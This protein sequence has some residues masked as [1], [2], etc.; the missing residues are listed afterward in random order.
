MKKSKGTGK[1]QDAH[2]KLV[3]RVVALLEQAIAPG[4]RV[5]HNVEL[6]DHK[7]KIMTQC[8][9]VIRQG[10][11]PRETITIVEVQERNRK[12]EL[13]DFRGWC[14]KR[15]DVGAQHLICVSK[16]G[17]PESVLELAREQGPAVRLVRFKVVNSNKLPVRFA[18][19]RL[20][21][22]M[23][24]L[25]VKGFSLFTDMKAD[26]PFETDRVSFTKN[27][28]P[29]S[30]GQL[31]SHVIRPLRF[32]GRNAHEHKVVFDD[33]EVMMT[34]PG[35][36]VRVFSIVTEVEVETRAVELTMS[37]RDYIQIDHDGVL[38][39]YISGVG[40]VEG[41]DA[42]MHMILIPT[43]DGQID[44]TIYLADAFTDVPIC[45]LTLVHSGGE[46]TREASEKE[47]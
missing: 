44:A 27:G 22:F 23:P 12:V 45:E 46:V 29:T 5:E 26:D 7:A 47:E 8:D 11:P 41:K 32:E 38:G 21:V 13:N 4:A 18:G 9:A 36:S 30:L 1:E 2:W 16:K 33:D 20:N 25:R 40:Q 3:E 35:H 43:S 37:G 19:D 10:M 39:W 14:Q 15:N 42:S 17:F 28:Q 24:R 6:F 31:T 34:W